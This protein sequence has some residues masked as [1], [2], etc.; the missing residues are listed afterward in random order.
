MAKPRDDIFS[1]A[2]GKTNINS[3]REQKAQLE[4]GSDDGVKVWVNGKLVHA[5]N[6]ARPCGIG[7]TLALHL[8]DTDVINEFHWSVSGWLRT[9]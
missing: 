2:I 3:M 6:A 8:R 9:A 5:N 4:I 1:A 7:K